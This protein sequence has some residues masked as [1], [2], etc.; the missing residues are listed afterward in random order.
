VQ[1][2]GVGFEPETA[3]KLFDAF[4]TTKRGGMGIG[5]SVSRTIIE[6]HR[7]RLW[8]AR[9]AGPGAT[10]AFAI[11]IDPQSDAA[12]ARIGRPASSSELRNT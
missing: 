7:G 8:G 6:S 10:F 2:A 5:L 4:F 9:N 11:P 12:V 3:E 1:D